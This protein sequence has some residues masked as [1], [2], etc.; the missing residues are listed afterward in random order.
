MPEKSLYQQFKYYKKRYENFLIDQQAFEEA[1]G[2]FV[3]SSELPNIF[4]N[5]EYSEI[6][7][8]GITRRVGKNVRQYKGDEAIK[9]MIKSLKNQASLTYLKNNFADNYATSMYRIGLPVNFIKEVHG[10]LKRM[11]TA[12]LRFI[13][14]NNYLPSI[15]FIYSEEE[16]EKELVD[17]INYALNTDF[18]QEIS[19]IQEKAKKLKP[20]IRERQKILK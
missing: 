13:L 19:K 7:S 20:L 14:G 16:S 18:N 8:K 6:F 11:S 2:G 9:V 1:R 12:K 17:R 4:S 5:L 15:Q 10:K 3:F